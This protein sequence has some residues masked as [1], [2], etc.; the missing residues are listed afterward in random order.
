MMNSDKLRESKWDVGSEHML[1]M[2]I[3][4]LQDVVYNAFDI[5]GFLDAH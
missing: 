3:E 1:K 5:A 4:S 2:V